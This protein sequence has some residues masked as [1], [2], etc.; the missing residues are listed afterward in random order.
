MKSLLTLL[1]FA[2]SIQFGLAQTP[3]IG[4]TTITFNDAQRTGG[5]GS[6]GG[7]GRQIQSEIYYPA[8]TTGDDVPMAAGSYPVV[9]FGHGFVMAWDA[10]ENVWEELVPQGYI[11]VFPRTEGGFSPDHN[12]FALDL[13]HL[14]GEMQ[15]EGTDIQSLFYQQV[16]ANN[17]IM[18]H[19]MGGGASFLAA[20]TQPNIQTVIGLAPAETTPSAIAVGN[21]ITIPAL[22]FSGSSDGVTPPADH[23]IPI[24]QGL[25]SSCKYFISITGGAHCYFANPNTNCDLG[26][27]LS[28]TGITVQRADQQLVMNDYVVDWLDYTLKGD[29]SALAS[30][31]GAL[32]GDNRITTM[33]DCTAIPTGIS[34][35]QASPLSVYPNPST[36]MFTIDNYQGEAWQVIDVLGKVVAQGQSAQVDLQAEADGVYWLRVLREDGLQAMKIV[37]GS[38]R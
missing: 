11:V 21:Q 30:F 20:G 5:F 16:D 6:G 10:Y 7:A 19:S 17:A 15:A 32:P 31:Q 27:T 25:S 37:R 4:H 24:Y 22:V 18:G 35:E 36:G 26:E 38:D 14:V 28:S 33:E 9:I 29:P 23:H 12:E 1:L 34:E 2:C 8:T 13:A 3:A